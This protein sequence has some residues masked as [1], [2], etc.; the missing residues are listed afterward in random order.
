MNSEVYFKGIKTKIREE[1]S[2]ASSS[3]YLAVAW[4]TDDELFE[5]LTELSSKGIGIQIILNDDEINGNSGLNLSEFYQNGGLVHYVDCKISLM[6]NKFCVIDK[7]TTINGSFNWTRKASSNLENITIFKDENISSKFLEQFEELTESTFHSNEY[8]ALGD[9]EVLHLQRQNNLDYD[10]LLIRAK[11]R[12]EN[13]SYIMAIYDYRKAYELRPDKKN[14]LFDLAYCQSEVHDYKNSAKNYLEYLKYNPKSSAGLN[15]LGIV[16]E[17]LKEFDKAIKYFSSAIELEEK[18][19]YYRNRARVYSSY[20]PNSGT[21]YTEQKHKSFENFSFAR[22]KFLENK[23]IM[24]I[25]DYKKIIGL[26]KIDSRVDYYEKIAEIF[27]TL[28]KYEESI[29]YYTR[30]VAN[31]KDNDYGYYSI[32]WSYYMLE[33]FDKATFYTNK[34]LNISPSDTSYKNLLGYIKKEKRKFKNWW[35]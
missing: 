23:G 22:I 18:V 13:K 20:L 11:K 3:V 10:K 32:A 33:N 7:K 6:H 17:E 4:L 8:K 2:K 25:K 27:Q 28:T 5:D 34:A 15:N 35:K 1:L 26:V 21:I 29:E 12:K 19:R 16:Y 24:A 9:D 31:T 30:V 14:V